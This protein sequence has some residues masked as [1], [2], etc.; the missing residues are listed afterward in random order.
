MKFYT[1]SEA[2]AIF[3]QGICSKVPNVIDIHYKNPKAFVGI[4]LEVAGHKYLAPLTSPKDWHSSLKSSSPLYFK[5]HENGVPEN[6][7]GLV[8][9]KFMF[10]ILDS[11][12]SLIDMDNLPDTPYK[13]MLYK[14]LQFIRSNSDT[15][16]KKSSL[17]R[18]LVLSGKVTGTCDFAALEERYTGF[19]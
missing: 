15:L 2:Y 8:N 14:Q 4:V 10:P 18:M 7:L 11:E 3:L 16:M 13:R 5:L 1:V 17:L 6:Q 12:V 19:K 9:L